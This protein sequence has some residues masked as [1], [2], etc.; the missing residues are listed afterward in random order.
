MGISIHFG[1]PSRCASTEAAIAS[2]PSVKI[3]ASTCT[4]SPRVRFAGNRPQSTSG[5]TP[6]I[7]TRLR[8]S[9]TCTTMLVPLSFELRVMSHYFTKS[10]C[11]PERTGPQTSFSLG[12]VSRRICGCFFLNCFVLLPVCNQI[13]IQ[14]NGLMRNRLPTEDLFNSA[15]ARVA[16][17]L[18]LF[19]IVEHFIQ[20]R[21]EIACEFF[22]MC[23]K[24]CD[25][26][27][28]EWHQVPSHAIHHHFFDATR[29]ACDHWRATGHRL[30]IDN[31]EWL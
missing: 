21:R 19:R 25:R 23:G 28:L 2:C 15:P 8:P 17:S 16:K 29:R 18:A 11:H 3:S 4:K 31:P 30:K 27:L 12:V 1:E 6:S 13:G 9:E 20:P 7:R 10:G 22:R 14:L 5:E 24:T 26:V